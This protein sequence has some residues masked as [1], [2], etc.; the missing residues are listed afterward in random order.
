MSN[1]PIISNKAYEV[2]LL[3]PLTNEIPHLSIY[4]ILNRQLKNTWSRELIGKTVTGHLQ[5]FESQK[6]MN[7]VVS[8]SYFARELTFTDPETNTIYD[9]LVNKIDFSVDGAIETE[10]DY[11]MHEYSRYLTKLYP[12]DLHAIVTLTEAERQSYFNEALHMIHSYFDTEQLVASGLEDMDARYQMIADMYFRH[13]F[14]TG[15]TPVRSLT[16]VAQQE[17]KLLSLLNTGNVDSYTGFNILSSPDQEFVITNKERFSFSKD[18]FALDAFYFLTDKEFKKQGAMR[19]QGKTRTDSLEDLLENNS[20]LLGVYPEVLE[21]ACRSFTVVQAEDPLELVD[22]LVFGRKVDS[23]TFD[24]NELFV[25]AT[26]NN[27]IKAGVP[28]TTLQKTLYKNRSLD[29]VSED[30]VYPVFS[31][32]TK[33]RSIICYNVDDCSVR[34]PVELENKLIVSTDANLGNLGSKHIVKLGTANYTDAVLLGVGNA[35]FSDITQHYNLDDDFRVIFDT[36]IFSR[37]LLLN[38]TVRQEG[39]VVFDGIL[40][41]SYIKG[42]DLLTVADRYSY[43]TFNEAYHAKALFE[44][45]DLKSNLDYL[46]YDASKEI[47]IVYETILLP[48]ESYRNNAIAFER[49]IGGVDYR[50]AM[51]RTNDGLLELQMFYIVKDSNGN[52]LIEYLTG[53]TETGKIVEAKDRAVS[54]GTLTLDNDTNVLTLQ[55]TDAEPITMVLPEINNLQAE[56]EH[57]VKDVDGN[58]IG[59]TTICTVQSVKHSDSKTLKLLKASTGFQKLFGN[60]INVD[61]H[62]ESKFQHANATLTAKD[63]CCNSVEIPIEYYDTFLGAIVRNTEYYINTVSNTV[64]GADYYVYATAYKINTQ[65]Y[66]LPESILS[67][68]AIAKILFQE[69]VPDFFK[70]TTC[71]AYFYADNIVRIRENVIDEIT[72]LGRVNCMILDNYSNFYAART[73]RA[74]IKDDYCYVEL[75]EDATGISS[76]DNKN[77]YIIFDFKLKSDVQDADTNEGSRRSAVFSQ[78]Y[79][80]SDDLRYYQEYSW[81]DLKHEHLVYDFNNVHSDTVLQTYNDASF[82]AKKTIVPSS[83]SYLEDL[84]VLNATDEDNIGMFK[85]LISENKS[86]YLDSS[87]RI[88]VNVPLNTKLL[89]HNSDY[90]TTSYTY[91]SELPSVIS[92]YNYKDWEGYEPLK[93]FLKVVQNKQES[94]LAEIETQV[95]RRM[96]VWGN[97]VWDANEATRSVKVLRTIWAGYFANYEVFKSDDVIPPE[98][99]VQTDINS[100]DTTNTKTINILNYN[101][102]E[103]DG[104]AETFW[105]LANLVYSGDVEKSTVNVVDAFSHKEAVANA[106]KENKFVPN[107]SGAKATLSELHLN[108]FALTA[109]RFDI[110]ES[111]SSTRLKKTEVHIK[112][113]KMDAEI[114]V[115]KK[116][117]LTTSYDVYSKM[118]RFKTD[119]PGLPSNDADCYDANT[120]YPMIMLYG[121]PHLDGENFTSLGFLGT[122][123]EETPIQMFLEYCIFCYYNNVIM[124]LE[125]AENETSKFR[126]TINKLR[127]KIEGLTEDSAAATLRF[128]MNGSKFPEGWNDEDA[129][130]A[131]SM[132]DVLN[133]AYDMFV[134]GNTNSEVKYIP[135]IAKLSKDGKLTIYYYII[136]KRANGS[137]KIYEGTTTEDVNGDLL[138]ALLPN[139]VVKGFQVTT[140]LYT[141][142]SQA[143]NVYQSI[144]PRDATGLPRNVRIDTMFD[145]YGEG[146]E[147]KAV[148]SK[149]RVREYLGDEAESEIKLKEDFYKVFENPDDPSTVEKSVRV[150]ADTLSNKLDPLQFSRLN[151]DSDVITINDRQFRLSDTSRYFREAYMS[152]VRFSTQEAEASDAD[153]QKCV[154]TFEQ[155]FDLKSKGYLYLKDIRVPNRRSN[156]TPSREIQ[157]LDR[158]CKLSNLH[159]IGYKEAEDAL[160]LLIQDSARTYS[161]Q[162]QNA[163]DLIKPTDLSIDTQKIVDTKLVLGFK[164]KDPGVDIGYTY[165]KRKFIVEGVISDSDATKVTLADESLKEAV[166]NG[167]FSLLD[168]V[169]SGDQVQIMLTTPTSYYQ[170]GKTVILNLNKDG[171]TGPYKVIYTKTV[172]STAAAYTYVILSGPGNIVLAKIPFVES[173]AIDVSDPIEFETTK[174]HYAYVLGT[175]EICYYDA[176]ETQ[177]VHIGNV[178]DFANAAVSLTLFE[179]ANRGVVFPAKV[180]ANPDDIEADSESG[181]FKVS[182]RTKLSGSALLEDTLMSTHS[183]WYSAGEAAENSTTDMTDVDAADIPQSDSDVDEKD[184][185]DLNPESLEVSSPPTATYTNIPM[186]PGYLNFDNYDRIFFE[187]G[188]DDDTSTTEWTA[189]PDK[190]EAFDAS[191]HPGAF[192]MLDEDFNRTIYS[193]D[194]ADAT[195]LRKFIRNT[196]VDMFENGG[197]VTAALTGKALEASMD[198]TDETTLAQLQQFAQRTSNGFT[199]GTGSTADMAASAFAR[200]LSHKAQ[201]E[202]WNPATDLI[203]LPVIEQIDVPVVMKQGQKPKW[204]KSFVMTGNSNVTL[205]AADAD[206]LKVFAKALLPATNVYR[207]SPNITAYQKSSKYIL[208][209]DQETATLTVMD[210]LGN[211]RSRL[212]IGDLALEHPVFA[213]GV[214]VARSGNVPR[215]TTAISRGSYLYAYGTGADLY[216][217]YRQSESLASA[218]TIQGLYNAYSAFGLQVAA[219]GTISFNQNAVLYLPRV[220]R[221]WKD[222]PESYW[223]ANNTLKGVAIEVVD[224]MKVATDDTEYQTWLKNGF[225]LDFCNAGVL[226]YAMFKDSGNA[227]NMSILD[228]IF[229]GLNL[230][231]EASKLSGIFQLTNST[232][233]NKIFKGMPYLTPSIDSWQAFV[234]AKLTAIATNSKATQNFESLI[235]TSNIELAGSTAVVYGTIDW[236]DLNAVKAKIETA[237]LRHYTNIA[238]FD[239]STINKVISEMADLTVTQLQAK[240]ATFYGSATYKAGVK[241]FRVSVDLVSGLVTASQIQ[242]NIGKNEKEAAILAMTTSGEGMTVLTDVGTFTAGDVSDRI[243]APDQEEISFFSSDLSEGSVA[244]V[245]DALKTTK[246]YAGL[247]VD[248][249]TGT[250]RMQ[251]KGLPVQN[252]DTFYTTISY[253][254]DDTIQLFS[255]V[256]VLDPGTEVHA[257]LL[258]KNRNKDNFKYGFGKVDGL[259]RIP[260]ANTLF[261]V[262]SAY[263]ADFLTYDNA[264]SS[265]IYDADL[266]KAMKPSV[267]DLYPT[268]EIVDEA[269]RSDFYNMTDSKVSYMK[270]GVGRYI[271]RITPITEGDVG[272][273]LMLKTKPNKYK[274]Y[275]SAT[276][277]TVADEWF[278]NDFMQALAT[279]GV[280]SNNVLLP[281]ARMVGK[282]YETVIGMY[283]TIKAPELVENPWDAVVRKSYRSLEVALKL[284][285]GKNVEDLPITIADNYLKASFKT[286]TANGLSGKI[287]EVKSQLQVDSRLIEANA[288]QVEALELDGFTA[289]DVNVCVESLILKIVNKSETLPKMLPITKFSSTENRDGNLVINTESTEMYI[290]SRGYGQALF[291]SYTV[292]ADCKFEDRIFFDSSKVTMNKAGTTFKL[293][294]AEGKPY[295]GEVVE[296]PK[297]MYR[298]FAQANM[299]LP[300][301]LAT[302]IAE[303][304]L[305]PTLIDLTKFN[306]TSRSLSCEKLYLLDLLAFVKGEK[307]AA[308]TENARALEV[309][310][311][312]KN[313]TKVSCKVCYSE[314][315]R[316]AT[317]NEV[318][319]LTESTNVEFV[320]ELIEKLGY[321]RVYNGLQLPTNIKFKTS[322]GTYKL[323]NTLLPRDLKSYST[324]IKGNLLYLDAEGKLSTV[325]TINPEPICATRYNKNINL[326]TVTNAEIKALVNEVF[327]YSSKCILMNKLQNEIAIGNNVNLGSIIAVKNPNEASSDYSSIQDITKDEESWTDSTKFK[328]KFKNI[329]HIQIDLIYSRVNKGQTYNLAYLKNDSGKVIAKIFFEQPINEDTLLVLQREM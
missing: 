44:T 59:S 7:G 151:V 313:N 125:D 137:Y 29:W 121:M 4:D 99:L 123:F 267:F 163:I 305:Q 328:F 194:S 280:N 89:V 300:A 283:N 301:E 153:I 192:E 271:L 298:S 13:K 216:N 78:I 51:T 325:K 207:L 21:Q 145:S 172:N 161:N 195:V 214:T 127:A 200:I 329:E 80:Y 84:T 39:K 248:T 238:G 188:E 296:M 203:Y 136:E 219:D 182:L 318:F 258:V 197:T 56:K 112:T 224:A 263:N 120:Y 96:V 173:E 235:K 86:L 146:N 184:L 97:V 25:Q 281:D 28:I 306:V 30:R 81:E 48:A 303:E 268:Y 226:E 2:E 111:E 91:S 113:L 170:E 287:T 257:I 12:E 322:D 327:Y 66:L 278:N 8:D 65:S 212:A 241:S 119:V 5:T 6:T 87:V 168:H 73:C 158:S 213:N 276:R 69:S 77:G 35:V 252:M 75:E 180:V 174:E 118:Y 211:L 14:L 233:E 64:A 147:V 122:F 185:K 34:N 222:K 217:Y 102:A 92:F 169:S 221:N 236:P 32:G 141:T 42:L 240:Y 98:S 255:D 208:A 140:S 131:V 116:D 262:N 24:L 316:D 104:A 18:S 43:K 315:P 191:G 314:L 261:E 202:T 299:L 189:L 159:I 50:V 243:L 150:F 285:D 246:A 181:N 225:M 166:A 108:T 323:T 132:T 40:N 53:T 52:D 16:G 242:L 130:R 46:I 17:E 101:Y 60:L 160:D 307:S 187:P 256:L 259:D 38:V 239:V 317:A 250:A 115:T 36:A 72:R 249:S 31:Y 95:S 232:V 152:N 49:N 291:G 139:N 74:K 148:L 63:N 61:F 157:I 199:I 47:D 22:D 126:K 294:D 186:D 162:V 19:L 10:I 138:Y 133:F 129:E 198:V 218:S 237:I 179:T 70:L 178:P 309:Y 311:L 45:Y 154:M 308:K 227:L 109:N 190:I 114:E 93:D 282:S 106:T 11:L 103:N 110:E 134:T 165:Y 79:R 295:N 175:G 260:V 297:L 177:V 231:N 209:W 266:K 201:N 68:V 58:A 41:T 265:G 228:L 76:L 176:D 100:S 57:I 277:N 286:A 324:D 321:T 205:D 326:F 117:L 312:F 206:S 23:H 15:I 210:K 71:K 54:R 234:N 94:S 251:T 167:E 67:I 288:G 9:A 253:A 244:L 3:S 290:P 164:W 156:Y 90:K 215:K 289:A 270:N 223:T 272:G 33:D 27:Y 196:L 105:I 88:L 82:L 149:E 144:L 264:A 310:E 62:Y 230:T 1:M 55:L 20:T 293:I 37:L 155:P 107:K 143:V 85:D 245:L 284:E 128:Y 26:K 229:K 83:L 319:E 254:T 320:N 142:Y 171:Y 279:A 183:E 273:R 193:V 220:L 247:T 302:K 135:C 275:T 124:N 304:E 269:K 292:P 274:D 204:Q